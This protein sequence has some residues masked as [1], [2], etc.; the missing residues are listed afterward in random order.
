MSAPCP[1]PA[2]DAGDGRGAAS[3]RELTDRELEVLLMWVGGWSERGMAGK[4]GMSRSGVRSRLEGARR[5]LAIAMEARN[6]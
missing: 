3:G 5:K 6:G 2:S 1:A 4:L